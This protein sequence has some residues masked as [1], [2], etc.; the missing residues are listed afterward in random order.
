[1]DRGGDVQRLHRIGAWVASHG[2]QKRLQLGAAT[3]MASSLITFV[4]LRTVFDHCHF[5]LFYD[6]L[7]NAFLSILSF[8]V[9]I[10]VSLPNPSPMH[11]EC[12]LFLCANMN[13]LGTPPQP[14]PDLIVQIV[15][16][17]WLWVCRWVKHGVKSECTDDE[18]LTDMGTGQNPALIMLYSILLKPL[19]LLLT[20]WQDLLRNICFT[21]HV[22]LDNQCQQHKSTQTPTPKLTNDISRF[23]VLSSTVLF[24]VSFSYL[25]SQPLLRWATAPLS[26]LSPRRYL[27]CAVSS[28]R[29]A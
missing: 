18:F 8:V 1:M 27:L 13:V 15:N 21:D 10:Y 16:F 5:F 14:H 26:Y 6:S 19:P 7:Y 20:S 22:H 2:H 25:F 3:D 4:K 28:L 11:G 12:V 24:L 17:E 23:F 9:V 29:I